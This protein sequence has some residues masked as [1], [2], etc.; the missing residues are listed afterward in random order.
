MS[1]CL[2]LIDTP[3]APFYYLNE[4]EV[5]NE[6]GV[7]Y[8]SDEEGHATFRKHCGINNFREPK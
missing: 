3:P 7:V 5:T 8:S 1:P 6:C 4:L 2:R